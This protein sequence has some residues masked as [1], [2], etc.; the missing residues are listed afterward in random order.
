MKNVDFRTKILKNRHFSHFIKYLSNHK[1]I[2]HDL[3]VVGLLRL[4]A[5]KWHQ[6]HRNSSC[7]FW[8]ISK[9]VRSFLKKVCGAFVPIAKNFDSTGIE[10]FSFYMNFALFLLHLGWSLFFFWWGM[11]Y[12]CS[13][14]CFYASSFFKMGNYTFCWYSFCDW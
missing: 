4:S 8:I 10:P 14:D 6:N 7:Q 12:N 13:L 2:C 5:L 3:G 9:T 11:T 1:E